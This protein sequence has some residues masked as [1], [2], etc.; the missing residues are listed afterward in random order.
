MNAPDV[1]IAALTDAPV[2]LQKIEDS[3]TLR[4]GVQLQLLRLDMLDPVLSGNKLFKLLPSLRAARRAG[5]HCLVSF[6]G[7]WSNHIHALAALGRRVGL[8]TVGVIRGWPG[9]ALT[10]TLADAER[11][12]MTL[13]YADRATWARRHDRDYHT[14]LG[15]RFGGAWVIP[16]GGSDA[17]GRAGCRQ[18]AGQLRAA[19]GGDVD[20]VALAVGTGATMAGVVT[21]LAP[22]TE[23]LGICALEGAGDQRAAVRA[24][25]AESGV[26]ANARW[27]IADDFA[28]GGFARTTRELLEFQRWFEGR[29]AVMLEP[30]YTAK[31]LLSL[32]RLMARGEFRRGSRVVAIHS[33]GLQG[34]RGFEAVLAAAGTESGS[35]PKM[36]SGAV[37]VA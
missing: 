35:F 22:S 2:P 32:Y 34:R 7:R 16:E 13:L 33:G 24:G 37:G 14:G 9:M 15:R 31:L 21:G 4:A 3:C 30:V 25:I 11:W 20:V 28:C 29:H 8:R 10:P 17:A 12:G 18:I 1:A 6:G 36:A 27:R 5:S 23:C 19:A 26:A